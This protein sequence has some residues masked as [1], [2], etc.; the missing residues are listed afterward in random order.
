MT[1]PTATARRLDRIT[2]TVALAGFSGL[3][4]VAHLPP[5]AVPAEGARLEIFA[6]TDGIAVFPEEATP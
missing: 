6:R 3:V 5:G 4:L 1:G 2:Q